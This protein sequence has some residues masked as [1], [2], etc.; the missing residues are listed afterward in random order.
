MRFD[1]CLLSGSDKQH[2]TRVVEKR[3]V[4]VTASTRSCRTKLITAG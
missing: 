3:V 1:R 4:K 2:D